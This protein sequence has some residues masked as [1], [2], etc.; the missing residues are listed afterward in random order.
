MTL[1]L[2]ADAA[3]Q[4]T[5]SGAITAGATSIVGLS[6]ANFPA[7][8]AGQQSSLIILDSGN[9]AFSSNS[10]LTTPYEYAIYTTNTVGTNTLSGITRGQAGTTAKAFFAG[11]TI[12]VPWLAEDVYASVPWKFDDQTLSGTAANI[13]IPASGTIPASYLGITWRHIEIVFGLRDTSTGTGT[14]F[15]LLRFNGVS[16]ATYTDEFIRSLA[17]VVA[18]NQNVGSTFLHLLGCANGGL[19]AGVFGSGFWKIL[20][21]T[22]ST[23]QKYVVGEAIGQT[24]TDANLQAVGGFWQTTNAPITSIVISPTTGSLATGSYATTYLI[25]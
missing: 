18:G 10:P 16:T 12:A 21:Y 1:R 7:P 4:T 8:A 3:A 19:A 23:M 6:T 15:A 24:L 13:T 5:V 14:D 25:P 11:A 2:L 17:A 20:N 22:S 9:P